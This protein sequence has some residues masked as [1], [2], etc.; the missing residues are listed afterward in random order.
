[1]ESGHGEANAADTDIHVHHRGPVWEMQRK[2][3]GIELVPGIESNAPQ[4]QT[5]IPLAV[6]EGGK[7]GK[8][9]WLRGK[10]LHGKSGENADRRGVAGLMVNE[11]PFAQEQREGCWIRNHA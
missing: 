3:L 7:H 6:G 5:A 9:L 10:P 4:F 11:D 8:P 1:M 2:P